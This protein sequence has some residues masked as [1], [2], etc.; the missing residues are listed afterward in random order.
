MTPI[1]E[2]NG[3]LLEW[4]QQNPTAIPEAIRRINLLTGKIEVVVTNTGGSQLTFSETNAVLTISTKDIDL[5]NVT[6]SKGSNAALTSLMT[7]LKR[8]FTVLDTTS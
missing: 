1:P 6:G 7:S 3:M 4:I 8:V 2:P 5:G